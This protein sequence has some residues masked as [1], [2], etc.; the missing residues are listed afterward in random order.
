MVNVYD[1]QYYFWAH[2]A[3]IYEGAAFGVSERPGIYSALVA[4]DTYEYE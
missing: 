1:T 3:G 2:W 4:Y